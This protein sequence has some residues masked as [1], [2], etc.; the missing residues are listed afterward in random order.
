MSYPPPFGGAVTYGQ[1]AG[2]GTMPYGPRSTSL[3][4]LTQTYG[5]LSFAQIYGSGSR[6]PPPHSGMISDTSSLSGVQ[7]HVGKEPSDA[8]LAEILCAN[9]QLASVLL[10]A[11]EGS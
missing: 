8:Q 11:I 1:W 10:A 5:Q 3:G 7:G 4:P 2:H 9:P 6:A